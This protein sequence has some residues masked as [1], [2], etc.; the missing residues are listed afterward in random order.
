MQCSSLRLCPARLDAITPCMPSCFLTNMDEHAL[1]CFRWIRSTFRLRARTCCLTIVLISVAAL[2]P[3]R[4]RSCFNFYFPPHTAGHENA[5]NPGA[6]T[7]FVLGP[8]S[9]RSHM[10]FIYVLIDILGFCSRPDWSKKSRLVSWKMSNDFW[11]S[12]TGIFREVKTIVHVLR[13]G[14]AC[15]VAGGTGK[16]SP[17]WHLRSLHDNHLPPLSA[18]C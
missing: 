15:L 7:V 11:F 13:A 2:A 9:L 3:L 16:V 1:T 12:S 4:W 14:L 17:P 5:A 10:L 18:A 6:S 8:T